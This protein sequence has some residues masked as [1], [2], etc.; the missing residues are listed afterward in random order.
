MKPQDYNTLV[1]ATAGERSTALKTAATTTANQQKL[2]AKILVAM[3]ATGDCKPGELKA[4]AENLTGKNIK[5]EFQNVYPLVTVF[6]AVAEKKIDLSEADFDT[7]D[8]SKL[9]LLA[10]FM[11]EKHKDK[12]P[13]ALAK[14]KSG[15]TAAEIRALKPK[16]AKPGTKSTETPA[17][18]IPVTF[19]VTDIQPGESLLRSRQVRDRLRDDM[20]RAIDTANKGEQAFLLEKFARAFDAVCQALD[21]DPLDVLADIAAER[22]T[23]VNGETVAPVPTLAA[24]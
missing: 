11:G 6:M 22:A 2:I 16:T 14:V 10:T 12:L 3:V 17:A 21:I 23:P 18:T 8:G 1:A 20:Q 19:A 15:G 4:H 24:A 13:D 5:E 7:L 9:A